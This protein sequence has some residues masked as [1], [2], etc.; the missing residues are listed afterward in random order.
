MVSVSPAYGAEVQ[1]GRM[2][3]AEDYVLIDADNRVFTNYQTGYSG[4]ANGEDYNTKD[5]LSPGLY[6]GIQPSNGG[7]G[8]HLLYADSTGTLKYDKETIATT[9]KFAAGTVFSSN[10]ISDSSGGIWVFNSNKKTLEKNSTGQKTKPNASVGHY[11]TNS[12]GKI[13]STFEY[14]NSSYHEWD[15]WTGKLSAN[16][17]QPNIGIT[18]NYGNAG[19]FFIADDNGTLWYL[20][21]T[22]NDSATASTKINTGLTGM[23]PGKIYGVGD[24]SVLADGTGSTWVCS[25][26]TDKSS[27]PCVKQPTSQ[28]L[29]PE[30]ESIHVNDTMYASNTDGKIMM[31]RYNKN[32]LSID[33]KVV[34]DAITV[35][36]G[37]LIQ[38]GC[39]SDSCNGSES[40]LE[41][42]RYTMILDNNGRLWKLYGGNP[43]ALPT[44]LGEAASST[45]CV[46]QTP[47]TGDPA[48]AARQQAVL[49]LSIGAIVLSAVMSVRSR[50]YTH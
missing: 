17:N 44:S 15:A 19:G 40:A 18:G 22:S 39:F 47:Q 35:T 3:S 46:Y 14:E 50:R 28:K 43:I 25:Y 26:I 7:I 33:W 30:T 16:P 34:S 12:E 36:P 9:A 38:G 48:A 1:K 27:N 49:F 29:S 4:S 31:G 32:S 10:L 45:D 20:L 21:H 13:Y 11:F 37:Q 42:N 24:T 8:A 23:T 6:K 41:I 5:S 2:Y